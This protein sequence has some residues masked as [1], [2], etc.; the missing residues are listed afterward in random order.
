MRYQLFFLYIEK[1]RVK[2]A[3]KIS[4]GEDAAK[5]ART[6][7][8]ALRDYPSAYNDFFLYDTLTSQVFN[9][10]VFKDEPH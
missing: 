5:L 10:G 6:A 7:E 3:H 1:N 8:H 4:T 9:G 2:H